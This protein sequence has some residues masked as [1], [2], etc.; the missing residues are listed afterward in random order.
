MNA[1][2]KALLDAATQPFRRAGIAAWQHA[3]GKL[4]FDPVF[5]HILQHGLLPNEGTLLDVGCG[6]GVLLALIIAARQQYRS[7]NWPAGWQAPPQ[8]L[9]LKG[10]ERRVDLVAVART[11]LGAGAKIE[12]HDV[13][14]AEFPSCSAVTIIDVLLYLEEQEQRRL[15]ARA[16]R[17]LDPG[18][19]LI[20]READAGAG[21]AFQVTKWS[22]YFLEL[23]RGRFR[24][25]LHYRAA[26]EWVDLLEDLD[27]IVRAEPMSSGTP[28]SNVLFVA[29]R[30]A[31]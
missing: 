29:Q 31:G 16:V 23:A 25:Q 21:A 22:E 26:G 5:F 20:L 18:G 2:R 15:L 19:V 14:T 9:S 17:A 11:A 27:M 3:R 6:R 4:R 30:R 8:E 13:R 1:L 10:L 7:G 28:F 24:P 12:Q